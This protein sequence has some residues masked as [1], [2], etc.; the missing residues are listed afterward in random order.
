LIPITPQ[1]EPADFENKVRRNG[2]KWLAENPGKTEGMP[3]LWSNAK[4]NL[5]ESYSRTCAYTAMHLPMVYSSSLD[6]FLPKSLHPHLAYEWSNFR[7]ALPRINSNKGDAVDVIDPFLIQCGWFEIDFPS[8]LI[9]PSSSAPIEII[10]ALAT[11]IIRLKLNDDDKLVQDR[12]DKVMLLVE[13]HINFSFLEKM[14]PFLAFEINRQGILNNLREFF[15]R[16]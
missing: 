7:L 13:Q 15:K 11:T 12:C 14:Y 5:Y 16:P 10:P 2:N 1:P 6:H 3:K 4:E 8:C 9:H